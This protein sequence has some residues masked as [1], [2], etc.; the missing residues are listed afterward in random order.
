M[1]TKEDILRDLFLY[2][3]HGAKM[4]PHDEMLTSLDEACDWA[5]D[6][7]NNPEDETKV[8][9]HCMDKFKVI[10]DRDSDVNPL[11]FIR[12]SVKKVMDMPDSTP[13]QKKEALTEEFYFWYKFKEGCV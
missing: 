2:C 13:E 5:L 11:E 9:N 3:V 4:I 6:P 10:I 12:D 8:V 1:K 7:E